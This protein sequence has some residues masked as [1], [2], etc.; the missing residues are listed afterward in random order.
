MSE[1]KLND[2]PQQSRQ[3]HILLNF[4]M[5][6]VMLTCFAFIIGNVIRIIY[7]VWGAYW[8]PILA[9]LLSFMSLMMRYAHSSLPQTQRNPLLLA[10]VEIILIVLVAKFVSMLNMALLGSGGIWRQILSW[11]QNGLNNFFNFD[12]LLRASGLLL[13]W[14]LTWLFSAP[15]NQLEEDEALM[16]QEKL[17]FTFTDRYEARRSLINLIFTIGIVM[18]IITVLLKSNLPLYT[19]ESR[20]TDYF[21]AI[22]LIYFFT[23]FIF[24]AL[25][26]YAI[27][28]ARW[29]F[30]NIQVNPDLAK[31]WVYYSLIFILFVIFVIAFLP[32]NF[33][34]GFSSLAQWL[35]EVIF[36]VMSFLFSII[37]APFVMAIALIERLLSGE[38]AEEPLQRT[39]PETPSF[40]PQPDTGIFWWDVVKSFIFW[41]VFFGAI[42]I[43]ISY[44]FNNKPNLKELIR[45]MKIFGWLR[46]FWKWLIQ[47][48]KEVRQATS[49]TLGTGLDKIRGF[50]QKQTLKLPTIMDLVRQLPPRQAVILIYV[51]W[52]HWNRRHGITRKIAQTPMEYANTYCKHLPEAVDLLDQVNALTEVFVQARYSRQKILKEQAQAAHNLSKQLKKSFPLSQELKESR[53]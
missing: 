6:S 45:E 50:L 28:K 42:F 3:I 43:A 46:E 20:P 18:I 51:D 39:T 12:T 14:L 37:I 24:L 33:S 48:F 44:Y 1:K 19:E 5:V 47:G 30:S 16:E 35:A 36:L 32:T 22:L 25:N 11:P 2:G 7:P 29:Y 41:L 38:P 9:F 26:Q 23:G 17:G 27:M 53:V 4:L 10:F 49:E 40:L 8:F 13:V 34:L 15:L 52:I 21:V 31:R